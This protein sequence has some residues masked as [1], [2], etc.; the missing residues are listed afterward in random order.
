MSAFLQ[1]LK[2]KKAEL[3]T[4]TH[5]LETFIDKANKIHNNKATYTITVYRWLIFLC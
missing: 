3:E 5:A 4:K 2:D 1:R